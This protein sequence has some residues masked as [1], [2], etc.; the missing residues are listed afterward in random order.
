MNEFDYIKLGDIGGFRA[1]ASTRKKIGYL[2]YIKTAI[3]YNQSLMLTYLLDSRRVGKNKDYS[4]QT[5]STFVSLACRMGKYE[6]LKVL[7]DFY[8]LKEFYIDT[9][10]YFLY[11]PLFHGINNYIKNIDEE[12]GIVSAG[13][14]NLYTDYNFTDKE[15]FE[16]ENDYYDLNGFEREECAE[17]LFSIGNLR[18]MREVSVEDYYFFRLVLELNR[19]GAARILYKKQYDFRS[20]LEPNLLSQY[21]TRFGPID[22]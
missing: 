6:P 7:I 13:K 20:N 17:L 11:F 4:S 14:L 21:E 22:W 15:I 5:I 3:R 12:V 8:D 10:F 2:E 16:I 1:F 9:A 18:D 19:V